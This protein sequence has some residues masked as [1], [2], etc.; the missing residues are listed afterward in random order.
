M[1]RPLQ[2]KLR[3]P[4]IT[5]RKSNGARCH[6]F[7]LPIA[8]VTRLTILGWVCG[9]LPLLQYTPGLLAAGAPA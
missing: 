2:P 5:L 7:D 3:R 4:R 8:R 9:I 1:S 6:K